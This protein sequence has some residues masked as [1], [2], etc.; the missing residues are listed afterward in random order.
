MAVVLL[1]GAAL[2]I[3]SFVNVMR[4][5]PGFRT[6]GVLA[7]QI[8][9]RASP[10][11]APADIRPA[12]AEI[13]DRARQLP[14]VID[15]AAAAPGIPFR[16]NLQISGL[17][18]PGQ[19]LDYTKTVSV[20][21]VTAG[22]HRTL[23]IPLRSGRYFTDD[24]REGAE[25]VVILSDAAA[26]MFFGDDDPL[27]RAAIVVGAGGERRVV[28]VVANA[29]QASLEVSPHPEV[30]LPVAQGS[31]QDYG[32]VLLHTS[33]DPNQVLP[34]LRGIVAQVLPRRAPAERCPAGGPLRGPDR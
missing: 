16:I 32:Y 2:F 20:K 28:G 7:A 9:Q 8:L 34:S 21:V 12:L 19:P 25:S 31:S 5:D 22:Y 17:Q 33:G 18:M 26:R 29:R 10:G 4:L 24:D 6:E 27:G 3:G 13:V 15:A 11:S 14:G 30:Y 23:A 1:V